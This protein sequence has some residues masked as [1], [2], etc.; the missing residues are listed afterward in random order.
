MSTSIDRSLLISAATAL[1]AP[2]DDKIANTL[3]TFFGLVAS[4]N[5]KFNLT[6][7]TDAASFTEKHLIDS[8]A[9]ADL[10]PA[11]ARVADIGAGAGFPSVPL[12][13][14]RPDISVTA[15]DSTEKKANFISQAAK[16]LGLNN[17]SS[18]AGRAEE[19]TSLRDTFDVVSARAV[20]SLP[21][22]CELALPLLKKGGLFLA[23]KTDLS[24]VASAKHALTVLGGT[25]K[26]A[27]EYA[28][29]SGDKRAV[30]VIEKTRPTPVAYPRRYSKIKSSPL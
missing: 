22:L 27:K 9:A 7:I 17:L 28:L 14:V 19:L 1:G 26:G 4:T 18:V 23:Y 20:A 15:I 12:A 6:A 3:D 10:I 24:E 13:V 29:P 30:I 11:D 2:V 25:T 5:E 8:L 16:E 21:V